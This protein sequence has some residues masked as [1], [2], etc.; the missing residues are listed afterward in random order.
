MHTV[1]PANVAERVSIYTAGADGN[2]GSSKYVLT[3]DFSDTGHTTFTAP[4]NAL[5]DPNTEYFVYFEDTVLNTAYDAYSVG[6]LEGKASE[7]F[8]GWSLGD[9][10]MEQ[11]QDPWD[12]AASSAII[13]LHLE[14]DFAPDNTAPALLTATV[15]GTSLVLTYDE[16]LDEDAAPAANAYSVTVGSNSAAAP[17]A[18]AVAGSAVTLTLATAATAGDTVTLGYTRPAADP[19]QDLAG[20]DAAALSSRAVANYTGRTNAAPTFDDGATTT[21]SVN[22]NIEGGVNVGAAVAATDTDTGATLTYSL[23]GSSRFAINPGTGRIRTVSPNTLDH[24]DTASYE[25]TVGVLDGLDLKGNAD[26]ELDNTITVTININN[27]DENGR[28]TLSGT[29]EGGSTLTASLT[30]PDGTTSNH[31]WSWAR[32]ATGS[33]PYNLVTG[34]TSST[35]TLVAADVDHWLEALVIYTDPHG[36]DKS[37]S[38][39]TGQIGAANAEPTFSVTSATYSVDENTA[40]ESTIGALES[41]TDNDG[42]TLSYRLT[43]PDMAFFFVQVD[44]H[45]AVSLRTTSGSAFDFESPGD[46]DGNNAYKVTFE[47][48]DAKDAA[49]NSDFTSDD[50]IAVTINVNNLDE[51]G[52]LTLSGME[53]G[54]ATLTATLTDLDGTTSNHRWRW[55]RRATQSGSQTTISGA[56]SSTYTLV[57][58]DVDHWLQAIVTYVDPQATTD[59]GASASTGQ[60][61]GINVKP[62]FNETASTVARSLPENSSAGTAVTASDDDGD[63]LTYSLGDMDASF[64]SIDSATGQIKAGSGV[65]NY[66]VRTTYGVTV[67]VHDGKDAA[68]DAS[69]AYDALKGVAITV[70]DVNE[71]P[72]ITPTSGT[73]T[74]PENSPAIGTVKA[75]AATDVDVDTTLTWEVESADDGDL[76]EINSNGELTFKVSPDFED[77]RDAGEDNTYTLTVKVTDNGIPGMSTPTASDTQTINVMVTNVNEPPVI[78]SQTLGHSAPSFDENATGVIATYTATDVDAGS[79]LTVTVQSGARWGLERMDCRAW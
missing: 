19:L 23:S 39:R 37:Q 44:I 27:L 29:E 17:S 10:Y 54:G 22:E 72:V 64:F 53:E 41:A 71:A 60:I 35:Y 78:T 30:D 48:S 43:G 50:S 67:R 55:T 14:G 15:D 51:D 62:V 69:T 38:A 18:V 73:A 28:L 75:F 46:D 32:R 21:R 68:G 47:V 24:E 70:T 5:L 31:Q 8:A 25:V 6:I 3:G 40:P 56:T 34:A 16:D 12:V 9:S 49:G 11:N 79:S 59:K 52:T 2:P 74:I 26:A 45:G 57:A 77:P 42:D 65:F 61:A 1:T 13:I 66:E 58:A 4:A 20:N 76:F 36:P 7:G 63:T 33:S